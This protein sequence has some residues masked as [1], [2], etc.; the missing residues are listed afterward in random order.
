MAFQVNQYQYELGEHRGKSVIWIHF[1]YDVQLK[2]H[3]KKHLKAKW[4]QSRKSWYTTDNTQYRKLF[5]LPEKVKG[6]GA[7]TKIHPIN[8]KPFKTYIELLKLK[9]YSISTIRTYSTEFAQLLYLLKDHPVQQLSPEKLRSYILYCIKKQKLS[10]NQIH[11]RLNAVK[12]YFEQVLH[13]ENFFVDIPRPKKRRRLPKV[14]TKKEVNKLF[15]VTTNPK[16]RLVLKLCY[17]MGLRVSEVVAIKME[18][19]DTQRMLVLIRRAKGK[20]DR[21]V[22]LPQSV[23]KELRNY[24]RKYQPEDFLFEGQYGGA[25]AKRSAQAV[26]KTAM[27]K[28]NIHKRVG[29]HSLRHSYATHLLEYG[30]D[31]AFIQKLLGHANIRTT[32]I[33]ARVSETHLAKVTSPLDQMDDS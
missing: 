14:L 28:A 16:H 4:S 10:E 32:G 12:F 27:R 31:M 20:R 22:P 1:P 2:E 13:R 23:L 26:F 6:K 11:S 17:G 8:Q 3:L 7:L 9:G 30:T 15:K 21:Y 5:G 25:Y 33:Y 29:I 24:Y 19:I 18:D